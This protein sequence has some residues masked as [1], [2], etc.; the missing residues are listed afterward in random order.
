MDG[1]PPTPPLCSTSVLASKA[2]VE[3]V[4][5]APNS[6]EAVQG[7]FNALMERKLRQL[8]RSTLIASRSADEPMSSDHVNAAR[9][10]CGM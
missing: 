4:V 3:A 2:R 10:G 5:V 7:T 1:L 6:A 9:K 8:V